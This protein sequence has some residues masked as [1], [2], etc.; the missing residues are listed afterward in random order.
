M[1]IL[2]I[3][4]HGA[5][6]CGAVGNGYQE[7]LLTREVTKLLKEELKA[8]ASVDIYDTNKNA[9]KEYKKGAFQIGSYDYALEV[10]FNAFTSAKAHGTEI[11]V[12]S[13]EKG[14]GVEKAILERLEKYFTNRGIVRRDDLAVI[15]T[16][17]NKGI[18]SALLEVCF[19]SN[20]DDMK[21]YQANKA[22][23]IKAVANGII[24]GFGLAKTQPKTY[25]IKKGDTLYSIAKKYLGNG[26]RYTDI[27]KLNPNIK[28]DNLQ[29]GATIKLP[30]N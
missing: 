21:I 6:D 9:Y 30:T 19:I 24:E 16:I 14:V 12:T 25:T 20:A 18:S 8:Y 23:I 4:G 2:L 13:Q 15:R 22:G 11:Y 1:K 5:G 3:S 10:H 28:A 17:K 26:N 29:I 27:L 7:Y